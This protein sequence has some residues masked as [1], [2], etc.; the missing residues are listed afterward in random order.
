MFILYLGCE[1]YLMGE[2]IASIKSYNS[3]PIKALCTQKAKYG[4]LIIC[5]GGEKRESVIVTK[6][7]LVYVSALPAIKL[8]NKLKDHGYMVL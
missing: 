3:N 2:I 1:T 6:E 8:I 7:G 5:T 4:Q